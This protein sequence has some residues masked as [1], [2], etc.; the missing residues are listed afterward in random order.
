MKHFILFIILSL[1]ATFSQAQAPDDH[2]QKEGMYMEFYMPD[3]TI[4][5][6]N[7]IPILYYGNESYMNIENNIYL[8]PSVPNNEGYYLPTKQEYYLGEGV[9]TYLLADGTT[10][11]GILIDQENGW[12]YFYLEGTSSIVD[13]LST[14]GKYRLKLMV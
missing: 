11:F 1:S 9:D 2:F 4:Y 12:Y 5:H 6:I 7:F 3:D 13:F 14:Y 8:V 10:I